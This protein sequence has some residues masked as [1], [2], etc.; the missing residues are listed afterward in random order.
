MHDLAMQTNW[1]PD[2]DLLTYR[3][4]AINNRNMEIFVR[5]SFQNRLPFFAFINLFYL[6]FA[7]VGRA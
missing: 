3:A 7:P 4:V 6:L 1:S 5:F 2:N